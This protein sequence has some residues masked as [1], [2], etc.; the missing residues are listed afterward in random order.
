MGKGKMMD[1]Y[2]NV[3]SLKDIPGGLE[4]M[5]SRVSG[6]FEILPPKI[7]EEKNVEIVS[8]EASRASRLY[9]KSKAPGARHFSL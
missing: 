4:G 2:F 5:K 9:R 3:Y 1:E 8:K 6:M 7:K